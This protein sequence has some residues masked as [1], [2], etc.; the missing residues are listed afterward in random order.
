MGS[1]LKTQCISLGFPTLENHRLRTKALL[2]LYC[3]FFLQDKAP[4]AFFMTCKSWGFWARELPIPS[5]F[6]QST[7]QCHDFH[8]LP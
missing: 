1:D 8:L 5:H 2:R 7:Q 6:L 4:V 3:I